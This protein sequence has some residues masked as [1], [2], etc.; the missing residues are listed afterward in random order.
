MK[1][2]LLCIAIL[3]ALA[4]GACGQN[5]LLKSVSADFAPIRVGS[6]WSYVDPAGS[7]TM[8]RKVVGAGIYQGRDAFT[9]VAQ[10]NSLPATTDYWSFSNGVLERYD[11]SLGGWTLLRRLPYVFTNKWVLETGNPLVTSVQSVETLET[12]T[13]PVGKIAGCYRLK[14]KTST[15]D[16]VNDVTSTVESLLWAAPN[17]GD[18]RYADVDASGNITVTLTLSSY[19][20]P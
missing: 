6:E 12:I 10:V 1:R 11:A 7:G 15:Y 8:T 20:I 5:P 19:R 9:V 13:T 4:L 14:T 2:S 17:I 16:A 3:G 18:V